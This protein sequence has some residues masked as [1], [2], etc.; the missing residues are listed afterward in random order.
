MNSRT[1]VKIHS[2]D[3]AGFEFYENEIRYCQAMNILDGLVQRVIGPTGFGSNQL[4]GEIDVALNYL[5]IAECLEE[6]DRR[7]FEYEIILLQLAQQQVEMIQAG[8]V[9]EKPVT[10]QPWEFFT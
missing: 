8:Q 5:E 6:T 3:K 10:V 1:S 4:E 7:F 9:P 2:M